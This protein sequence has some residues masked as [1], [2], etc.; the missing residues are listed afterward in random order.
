LQEGGRKVVGDSEVLR[1]GGN[2]SRYVALP[3]R[4]CVL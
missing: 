1:S 2:S 4:C 3:P